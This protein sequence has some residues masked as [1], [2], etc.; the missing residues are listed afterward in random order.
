MIVPHVSTGSSGLM[1]A[2]LIVDVNGYDTRTGTVT[3]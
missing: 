1:A 2:D 3:S